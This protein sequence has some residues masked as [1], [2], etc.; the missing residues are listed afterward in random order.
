MNMFDIVIESLRS[1][2]VAMLLFLLWRRGR[3]E[4]LSIHAGWREI[5]CGVVLVL[6]ASVLDITDNFPALNKFVIIGDTRTEAFLEKV[7]GYLGGY[8]LLFIGFWR[9]IF[10]AAELEETHAYLQVKETYFRALVETS[11]DWIWAVDD[12]GRYRYASPRVT[13]LLGYS[14]EEVIGLTPFDF[15]P[16]EEADRVGALFA[17]IAATQR[18]FFLLENICLHKDG[19]SVVLE[20]SGI[21]LFDQAGCFIGYQGVD[22]DITERIQKERLLRESEA[23]FRA[24]FDGSDLGMIVADIQTH[25]FVDVN[26]AICTMLGYTRAELLTKGIEHIHPPENL[27]RVLE[28]FDRQVRGDMHVASD[29][30][31]LRQNGSVFHADI[32]VSKL[33]IDG[34]FCMAGIFTDI[35]KRRQ[36]EEALRKSEKSLHRAQEVAHVGSWVLDIPGDHIQWSDETYRIFGIPPGT[37]LTLERFADC[38]HPDD[39]E[40]VLATWDA[41]LRGARYDIEHRILVADQTRWVRECGE[42]DFS[43][44]GTARLGIGSV[45][46]ITERKLTEEA[47]RATNEVLRSVIENAPVRVFWKD[48]DSRYL[49]CNT[50]FAHDA[51]LDT[52]Q[53]TIG[54]TDFD[55]V[56]KAQAEMYRADDRIVMDSDCSKLGFEEPQT[57]PDGK[58]I[59]LRTSKVPLRD[60][61]QQVYGV[62]GIYE[63]ITERKRILDELEHY[64]QQLEQLVEER[65]ADLRTAHNR[66]VDTQFAMDSVG[67][68]IQWLDFQ[69]GRIFYVNRFAASS[70]GYTQ[71][72]MLQLHVWDIDPNLSKESFSELRESIRQQKFAE[73]ETV[74]RAKDGHDTPVE[75]SVYYQDSSDDRPARF[76][77]FV[78]DISQRKAA[79]YILI[80]AK[81]TAEAANRAKTLFLSNM[82][83]ELRTPLNAIL[84][85][86][87]LLARDERITDDQR[88]NIATI[89]RAGNHLLSLINDV[90]EISR[91]EA[92]RTTVQN[93]NFDLTETLAII[94]EMV[95]LRTEQKGLTFSVEKKGALPQFVKGDAH[96]LRQV[97]INLLANAVKYTDHG[98]IGLHLI[99]QGDRILFEVTDT[100]CGIAAEDLSHIFHA[101][102][103]T[104]NGIA[105]G[106]G[107][108]LGLTISQEFVRLMGGTIHVTSE[109]GRGSKFAFSIPL[110]Q[111]DSPTVT[112]ART[113]VLSLAPNQASVRVLVTEDND[114]NR[115]LLVLLLQ[116]AGFEVHA[117][118]N[119]RE[120]VQTFQSWQP[121]FIWMDMRMPVMNG[122]AAT[123]AIRALPGGA[124]VK[125]VA[126]T[127]SAFHEDREAILAAG[128]DDLLGKPFDQDRIFQLMGQQ[129]HLE[130][131]Y[132]H[133]DPDSASNSNKTVLD[134][135]EVAADLRAEMRKAAEEL[136]VEACQEIVERLRVLAPSAAANLDKLLQD[137]NFDRILTELDRHVMK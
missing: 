95:R 82:S 17:R 1:I 92:G 88:Q 69:S 103:Q 28:I 15:M 74:H 43:P 31:V 120:A 127:A 105:K 135:T 46:D 79:E 131:S 129:L 106:E 56:W 116:N 7:V 94:Q 6:L 99:P 36:T 10:L 84:G 45:Q 48:R 100:G 124:G 32:S 130:Y 64:R 80:Q 70:L 4:S 115:S 72:E 55:M 5:L 109:P 78:K 136:D 54:A 83:H 61:Q 26:P 96:H 91:I 53:E 128:C 23:R 49:G 34:E 125:I 126:L 63:D 19:H 44:E 122:Y 16:S 73:H 21:P 8:I 14:P 93:E 42:V 104:E 108:G 90:L 76:I 133:V 117:A 20:T 3:K 107:T 85:F 52:P 111:T 25:R 98:Q 29:I 9:W 60:A 101:F 114:D 12:K 112:P 77:A 30:P 39:R 118:A 65:T 50:A 75:V 113:R 37:P 132:S 58:L 68:G 27:P 134:L 11:T 89:N 59:W 87:Q 81:E 41:A 137:F 123:E 102:Y 47:L 97:L 62:L 51:G 86:S 22:R 18:P 57:T 121:D 110:P 24:L 66:L 67:I 33:K 13:D 35:T 38:I 119:G 40:N 2:V 71:E